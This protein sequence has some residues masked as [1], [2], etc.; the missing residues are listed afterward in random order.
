M[1]LKPLTRKLVRYRKVDLF[2]A[3]LPCLASGPYT[4]S[5]NYRLQQTERM[6][7]GLELPKRPYYQ[8]GKPEAEALL[9]LLSLTL[10]IVLQAPGLYQGYAP[11]TFPAVS[12][13]IR[14]ENASAAQAQIHQI[15]Y[16]IKKAA[17][18]LQTGSSKVFRVRNE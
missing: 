16:F 10:S 14:E 12:Q 8:H 1:L 18:F 5:I 9:D 4:K 2:R 17:N 13:A 3:N 6:F 15:A 11:E 7:I